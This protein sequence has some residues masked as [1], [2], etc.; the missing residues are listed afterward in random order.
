MTSRRV[1]QVNRNA[2]SLSRWFRGRCRYRDLGRDQE[3]TLIPGH[4][5][6]RFSAVERQCQKGETSRDT[7]IS[8]KLSNEFPQFLSLAFLLYL[9]RLVVPRRLFACQSLIF[10]PGLGPCRC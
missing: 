4:K 1:W 7:I 6:W 5:K 2:T 3:E 8:T 9:C 10:L